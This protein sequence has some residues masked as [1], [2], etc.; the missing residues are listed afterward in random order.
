VEITQ[1]NTPRCRNLAVIALGILCDR[2]YL[3]V[4]VDCALKDPGPQVKQ[5][6]ALAIK[7]INEGCAPQAII[8]ALK[9]PDIRTALNA[10]EALGIIRD[11]QSLKPLLAFLKKT[12]DK[13]ALEKQPS[14]KKSFRERSGIDTIKAL[15]ENE[16]GIPEP[17]YRDPQ[18]AG[19]MKH[20]K[21][22][23]K[24]IIAALKK[25]VPEHNGN[26]PQSWLVWGRKH[27]R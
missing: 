11:R 7:A 6:A 25:I 15:K 14:Q 22:I 21:T 4:C 24:S 20:R 9:S 16:W 26:T 1:K 10:V 17:D 13:K 2:E 19:I 3:D 18:A 27:V 8:A 12:V 23:Q 5:S